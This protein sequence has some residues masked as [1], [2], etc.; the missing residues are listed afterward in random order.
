MVSY[1]P[2]RRIRS[3][4]F[5]LV[6]IAFTCASLAH[7][8]AQTQ[9]QWTEA[10]NL[11]FRGPV[12]SVV[13]TSTEL[14][15]ISG[16]EPLPVSNA[17]SRWMEFDSHGSLL[18]QGQNIS[19][20]DEVPRNVFTYD[21]TGRLLSR[22]DWL[23]DGVTL[24]RQVYRYGPFG[25]VEVKWY[26]GETL[27]GRTIVE[28]DEHGNFIRDA[29]YDADG[30]LGHQS[31]RQINEKTNTDEEEGVDAD[32]SVTVHVLDSLDPETGILEHHSFDARGRTTGILRLQNGE[33]LSWWMN[34]DFVCEPGQ[35]EQGVFNWNEESRRFQIYFTLKCSGILEIT[36]LHHA[37]KEGSLENDWE[38]RYLED[39]TRLARV[40]NTYERDAHGNWTKLVVSEWDSKK[41]QM[42]AVRE[43]RRTSSYFG[44]KESERAAQSLTK[45]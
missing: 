34:P 42:T 6:C 27:N 14:R 28:Y 10:E 4:L 24:M 45:D 15:S 23:P 13:A 43:I 39:G 11:A 35:S 18:A 5:A 1:N 3:F 19:K 37:G 30:K 26:S 25:P 12:H 21:E 20:S 29:S 40:E 16:A 17:E 7:A 33:F 38:E 22:G 9:H 32:G 31:L 2:G 36:K 8:Q 44:E 41:D